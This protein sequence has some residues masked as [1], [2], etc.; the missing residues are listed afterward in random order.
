MP[1]FFAWFF[2]F[3]TV[4]QTVWILMEWW[5][6][7]GRSAHLRATRD[8]VRAIREMCQNAANGDGVFQGEA[9]RA[10]IR[11]L[12]YQL[13]SIEN[14]IGAAMGGTSAPKR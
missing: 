6:K 9:E 13:R 12:D 5:A 14:Q 10:W 11:Q 7:K 2:G 8:D 4:L 1:T 3:L